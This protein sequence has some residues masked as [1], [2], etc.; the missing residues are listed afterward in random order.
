MRG[1][2]AQ[3]K[4]EL[5]GIKTFAMKRITL[6]L[7]RLLWQKFEV[8]QN[9]TAEDCLLTSK[10]LDTAEIWSAFSH[11]L[12]RNQQANTIHSEKVYCLQ[13]NLMHLK[14]DPVTMVTLYKLY[15]LHATVNELVQ[16]G[17]IGRKYGQKDCGLAQSLLDKEHAGD[18]AEEAGK[19]YT[20]EEFKDLLSQKQIEQSF[21]VYYDQLKEL[22]NPI[23][24]ER[25]KLDSV[26]TIKQTVHEF[27]SKK[28]Q[29]CKSLLE[30]LDRMT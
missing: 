8:F 15:N 18:E 19:D 21:K 11:F 22:I 14:D 23:S 12:E 4:K 26:H 10:H 17:F 9:S 5:K 28:N 25:L 1:F 2:T 3:H 20:E 29:H 16:L 27:Y 7:E 6:A 24:E 30:D 13:G